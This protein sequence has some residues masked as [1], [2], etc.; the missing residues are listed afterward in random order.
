[1]DFARLLPPTTDDGKPETCPLAGMPLE[2]L[3]FSAIEQGDIPDATF[4]DGGSAVLFSTPSRCF[5]LI[6]VVAIA[7]SGMERKGIK[8]HQYI[9]SITANDGGFT[10]KNQPLSGADER[11]SACLDCELKGL[12]QETTPAMLIDPLRTLAEHAIAPA[13]IV[14]HDG[15]LRTTNAVI[16]ERC[17]V[18]PGAIALAKTSGVLTSRNR[19]LGM[20][21]LRHAPAGAWICQ[22]SDATHCVRL[23]PAASHVFLLEG[24]ITPQALSLLAAWSKDLAFPGYPYPLQLADQLARVTNNERDA[25]R[26]ILSSDKQA[27]E[28]LN[29]EMRASDAH[30]MLEHILYGKEL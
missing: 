7:T 9:V 6:K 2:S 4:I 27:Q 15:S 20:A 13:G 3:G 1:M 25:W 23:H 24:D 18:S 29:S 8:A 11:I 21:L 22:L 30:A 16:Q 19:P 10:V 5:G 12:P 17:A 26:I 28:I 14:I